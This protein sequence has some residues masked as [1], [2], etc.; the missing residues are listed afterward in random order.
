MQNAGSV[1][2]SLIENINAGF[3]TVTYFRNVY[4]FKPLI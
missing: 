2:Y 4:Y 1:F 3:Q